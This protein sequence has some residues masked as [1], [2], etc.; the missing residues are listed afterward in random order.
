MAVDML[1]QTEN[2]LNLD[3]SC[4]PKD[5]EENKLRLP[6]YSSKQK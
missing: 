1:L 4:Y 2:G 3:G 6:V 5:A